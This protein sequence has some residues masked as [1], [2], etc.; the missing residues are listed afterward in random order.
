[1][2]DTNTDDEYT[3]VASSGI[4]VRFEEVDWSETKVDARRTFTIDGARLQSVGG[5]ITV[6]EV[7]DEHSLNLRAK[8]KVIN[9]DVTKKWWFDEPKQIKPDE[10]GDSKE[11][12]ISKD[13][14]LVLPDV[15]DAD[16]V[17]IDFIVEA[18]RAW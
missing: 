16:E 15:E 17:G 13:I 14:N 8:V 7:G 3:E 5:V 9:A 4:T 10:I 18:K 12:K 2:S 6:A 11:I 1:M